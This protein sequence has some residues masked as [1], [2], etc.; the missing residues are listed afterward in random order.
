MSPVR[1]ALVGAG[2]SALLAWLTSWP[3]WLGFGTLVVLVMFLNERDWTLFGPHERATSTS[4]R[5]APHTEPIDIGEELIDLLWSAAQR[6]ARLLEDRG[7]LEAFVMYEDAHGSVRIRPVAETDP[8]RVLNRARETARSIDA[9][10]PRVVLAAADA[11]E[12]DGRRRRVV[13]YEAAER[14]FRDRT[15]AF[16]QPIRPRRLIVPPTTEGPLHYLGEAGHSLRF[17]SAD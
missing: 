15:Y 16:A 8:D 6:S 5:I 11:F 12:L 4:L 9:S 1:V 17:S 13:R 7:R 3:G 2:I 10:A 14:Q